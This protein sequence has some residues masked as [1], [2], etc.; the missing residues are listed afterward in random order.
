M[1]PELQDTTPPEDDYDD[2]PSKSQVKREM[3]ALS[4]LGNEV[5]ALSTD[6]L[7][8]LPISERFFEAVREA[9]RATSREGRRRS[10]AY[11]GKLMRHEPADEI[12][13][14]LDVWEN[15]SREDTRAMHRLESMR[16]TLLEDDD[17]LTAL[18]A[19]IDQTEVQSLRTLVRAARKEAAGNAQLNPGQEPQR[20]HYRALFQS[21]K[22]LQAEGIIPK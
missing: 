5:I 19:K 2:R 21:L 3:H 16:D 12:R 11:V 18:L 9:Q 10:A 1:T 17:A 13:H 8:Q 6:R 14:Q 15:G 4:D 7:K 20:K 22:G